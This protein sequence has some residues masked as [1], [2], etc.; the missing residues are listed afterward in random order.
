VK[1]TKRALW[2]LPLVLI[3]TACFVTG[4]TGQTT[5][6]VGAVGMAYHIP[7]ETNSSGSNGTAYVFVDVPLGWTVTSVTYDATVNRSAVS[8]N[9]TT[10]VA[11]S[12]TPCVAVAGPAAGYQRLG[13]SVTFPTVTA[14][15][16][17]TLHLIFTISGSPGTF[18]L[19]AFGGGAFGG[20]TQECND[21]Q[22]ETLDVN[23]F[24]E[25]APMPP[26]PQKSF[27]PSSIAPGGTSRLMVRLTN[28]NAQTMTAVSFTDTYPTGVATAPTPN[29][30]NTCGGTASSTANSLSLS[31]GTIA[32]NSNCEVSIDVTAAAP[33]SYVNTIPA[34]T[35]FS[36][37]G[38]PNTQATSATLTAAAAPAST[39]VP[40]ASEWALIVMAAMLAWVA[41]KRAG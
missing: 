26:R 25:I 13:F 41:I 15:D 21:D 18:T 19:R 28:P 9:A 6:N 22:T 8:G 35:V 2:I 27:A 23:V 31:A 24:G 14:N 30:A 40:A 1:I 3:A 37:V 39:D 32:G 7:F 11:Q 29:I 20:P 4:F 38:T 12:G 16:S 17:G 33:G 36:S 10:G 34:G 5:V